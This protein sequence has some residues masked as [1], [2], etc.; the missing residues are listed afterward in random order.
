MSDKEGRK[1]S[2][3]VVDD[4]E[5]IRLVLYT[6]LTDADY[7]CRVA[8]DG[9]EALDLLRAEPAEVIIA[10]YRMPEMDGLE[11]LEATW[12]FSPRPK[13]IMLT[14]NATIDMAMEA[15]RHGVVTIVAKPFVADEFLNL[16]ACTM[17]EF[18]ESHGLSEHLSHS[19][20]LRK[21][22]EELLKETRRF[23]DSIKNQMKNLS[24]SVESTGSEQ[25]TYCYGPAGVTK[26]SNAVSIIDLKILEQGSARSGIFVD[27]DQKSV[28]LTLINALCPDGKTIKLKPV[29]GGITFGKLY[30]LSLLH[31]N[32]IHFRDSNG[33]II[34]ENSCVFSYSKGTMEKL[35]DPYETLGV[36]CNS[37]AD[38]VK[39]AYMRIASRFNN[40]K[41]FES[42]AAQASI[43]RINESYKRIRQYLRD[44]EANFE[45]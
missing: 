12:A 17:E 5:E 31:P 15:A 44:L 45:I 42:V 7:Y 13:T 8:A 36:N 4:E 22:S 10:D 1:G 39:A 9:E 29:S 32:Y 18:R 27:D 6:L 19:A 16:I 33:Q 23:F 21:E 37:T 2:I 26:L 38:E 20:S 3:L 43:A 25:K 40:A 11:F 30:P 34:E 24:T 28:L 41:D 35:H 14:G